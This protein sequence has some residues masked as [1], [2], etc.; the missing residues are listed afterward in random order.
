MALNNLV[1]P[2]S[3][4][5]WYTAA[6]MLADLRAKN[7]AIAAVGPIPYFE[8]LFP[9]LGDSLLGDPTLTP[10]QAMYSVVAREQVGGLTSPT[11]RS[12]KPSLMIC[13]ASARMH[14]FILSMGLWRRLA[15]WVIL[16]IMVDR[17]A[18]AS[19]KPMDC[20]STSITPS[21]NR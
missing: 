3:R 15:A 10:T 6:G 13:P 8:N 17:S 16:T 20:R 1:D 4:T 12:S 21:Q 2:R 5:D 9:G 19:V 7:T 11:G 18:C 14:S